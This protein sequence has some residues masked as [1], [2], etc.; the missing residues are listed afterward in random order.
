[1]QCSRAFGHEIV[2]PSTLRPIL[3]KTDGALEHGQCRS[4]ACMGHR[5]HGCVRVV[6]ECSLV[7]LRRDLQQPLLRKLVVLRTRKAS[8]RHSP[9]RRP[10]SI[11][12]MQRFGAWGVTR[13]GNRP[14]R[15]WNGPS[16]N[17]L[18]CDRPV[19]RSLVE[20]YATAFACIDRRNARFASL[21]VARLRT[22]AEALSDGLQRRRAVGIPW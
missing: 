5:G 11:G 16:A 18:R 20:I 4:R 1:M 8:R 13:F 17:L 9:T 7:Q 19:L 22:S 6:T 2:A 14:N 10:F 3:G 21:Q 15:E 12:T